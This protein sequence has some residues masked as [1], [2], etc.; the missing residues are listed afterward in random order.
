MS[1]LDKIKSIISVPDEDEEIENEV[2]VTEEAAPKKKP[3][4]EAKR[5][6]ATP[7]VIGGKK[8][9]QAAPNMQLVIVKPERFDEV[10]SI[11]DHMNA[12]K[13]V[14]LNLE[15]CDRDL[16]RRIIDFLS[17]AVY[18][19]HGNISKSAISSFV[20]VPADV[21]VMGEVIIDEL[22]DGRMYF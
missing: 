11:A 16:S 19:N 8:N 10:T 2:E 7:R 1:L 17:G 22:N 4:P 6:P 20:I 15:K 12:K 18:A 3:Q 9:A 13:I 14:L 21:D 5:E